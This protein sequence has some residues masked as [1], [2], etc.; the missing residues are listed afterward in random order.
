MPGTQQFSRGR[1]YCGGLRFGGGGW[2]GD[3]AT[4]VPQAWPCKPSGA[5]GTQQFREDPAGIV[6]S[7]VSPAP[8]RPVP[9]PP[10]RRRSCK[11]H[12]VR[13]GAIGK[14][15]LGPVIGTQHDRRNWRPQ[16]RWGS[17]L[18]TQTLRRTLDAHGTQHRWSYNRG[19]GTRDTVT[20]T[21]HRRHSSFGKPP[22]GVVNG[23]VLRQPT[24]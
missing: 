3:T 20:T 24:E 21:G 23:S 10:P 13:L 17:E 18:G 8:R 2:F 6:V 5:L 16:Y 19:H 7:G 22:E 1:G 15:Y 14:Q 4:L 12:P 11:L 9:G